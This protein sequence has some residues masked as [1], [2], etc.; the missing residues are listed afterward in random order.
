METEAEHK[1][2]SQQIDIDE[3]L[4]KINEIAKKSTDG[5]Y[6]YRGEAA[7][8]EEHPYCGRVTSGLYRHY[9][10]M[11]MEDV[12]V[13]HVQSQILMEAV[14]YIPTE[15]MENS[16]GQM[17]GPKLLATLQHY[18]D[19]T[20]LIDF[21]TDYLIALFF[22]CDGK[23]REP[24]RVILLPE[25][26]EDEELGYEVVK[27]SGT[28]RRAE[29]QK[30]IFVQAPQGFVTPDKDKVVCIPAKLKLALLDY[31]DKHHDI[32]TKNIY[33]DLHGFIEK[34]R[35]HGKADIE[36]N[37]GLTSHRRAEAAKTNKE[38]QKLY[39]DAITHYTEAIDLN[40]ELT[41]VSYFRGVAYSNIG[42]FEAAIR[43]FDKVINLDAKDG[44]VYFHR[45]KAWLHLKEWQKAKADL[46]TAK[47]MRCD[48]ITSF[49]N[50]CESVEAFEA[51][52]GLQVPED[53]AALLSGNTT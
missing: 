20:N 38:R 23:P 27:R 15:A 43:D 7:H 42:D 10:E 36:F 16:P 51:K 50:T 17:Y 3:V 29:A 12:N 31:L 37:K 49:Q 22:A 21:T 46:T 8:H 32:S 35:L 34:R 41:E 53:I 39:D 6:I 33:N 4:E 18:G 52:H 2:S 30:S 13:E 48:I 11:G 14:E 24:G 19:K 1:V 9:L 44:V 40:P 47:N 28:I 25:E 45:G 26:S 5:D